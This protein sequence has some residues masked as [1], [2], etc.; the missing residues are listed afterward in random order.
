MK[1]KCSMI[2]NKKCVFP[3][4]NLQLIPHLMI[5]YNGRNQ[6][7]PHPPPFL[8]RNI[9]INHNRER[10]MGHVVKMQF[11]H[12]H[13]DNQCLDINKWLSVWITES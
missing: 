2:F 5:T 12:T 4:P 7:G 3:K 10:I 11:L 9:H 13:L 1:N 8:A 6:L